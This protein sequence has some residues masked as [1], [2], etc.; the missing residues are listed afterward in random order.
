MKKPPDLL[1]TSPLV[2]RIG[3]LRTLAEGKTIRLAV[4]PL[5]WPARAG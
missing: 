2:S 3:R 4:P 1:T 5:P